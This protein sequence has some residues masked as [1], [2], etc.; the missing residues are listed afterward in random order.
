MGRIIIPGGA[1]TLEVG[2]TVVVIAA[3]NRV[4]LDLN[5]VFVDEG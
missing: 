5:D 2:D 4:I 1:D 3:A